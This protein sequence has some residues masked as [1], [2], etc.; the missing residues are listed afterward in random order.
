MKFVVLDF[1]TTGTGSDAEIIQVGL[2]T[3]DNN[4]ITDRYASFVKPEQPIPSFITQLTGIDDELVA[5]APDIE[6]VMNDMLPFLVDRI[7]VG[8]QVSFD[9]RFLQ[10]ELERSGY[11]AFDGAVLDTQS[12]LRICFPALSSLQL[13]NVCDALDIHHERP[14]RADSDAE[15]TAEIWLKCL[16]RIDALP[17]LTVQRLADIFSNRTGNKNDDLAWFLDELKQ[18][19]E[20]QTSLDLESSNYFRQFAINVDDWDNEKPASYEH[21]IVLDE[22]FAEF[23]D[24]LKDNLAKFFDDFEE[25]PAQ[26]EMI[27]EVHRAFEQ[28]QHLMIEAGTGT[29]KSLGYLIPALFYG[30]QQEEKVIVSTHTINLQEQ[31][32]QRD[33]PLLEKLFPIPF[34]AA[35]LKGRNHYLC[36]RKFEQKINGYD[37][38]GS[39]DDLYT[40]AQ[41]VVWLGETE[42][43][44]DE[45]IHFGQGGK[46]FWQTVA[47]DTDSCLNRACPWFKKCFYHRARHE[48]NIADVVITNHSMLF[49]DVKADNRLLPTYEHLVIDEAHHFEEVAT[50]HLGL[51]VQYFSFL[52]S[53]TYLFKDSSTGFLPTLRHHIRD[54]D[55]DKAVEWRA[56]IDD[57][58]PKIIEAKENWDKLC[59]LLYQYLTQQGGSLEVGAVLRMKPGEQPAEWDTLKVIEDN[60]YLE[61]TQVLKTVERMITAMKDDVDSFDVQSLVTDGNGIIKSIYIHLDALRFFMK[62]NDE[63]YVYWMEASPTYRSKSLQL[64]SVPIDVSPLLEQHFFNNKQSVILTSA[65]LTVDRSFQYS[66]EQL[67][68]VSS[69][70]SE[71]LRTVILPPT[72]NFREQ[73][74]VCIPRDFPKIKGAAGEFEFVE[75][76]VQSL[77]DVA[78]V[79]RGRMLVLFTSY[80]MLR[81]VHELLKDKMQTSGI[82]VLGQGIDSNNRSKLIHLFQNGSA[83]ILLGTSSFWEGIDIP[84]EALSCL[85][86][87]RLPFQPPNQPIVEAKSDHI[88]KQNGNP[89]MKLSVPQAVIRFKQGFGRLVRKA[90]DRGI[91][92]IYDTRVIE[93]RYGKNFLYSL[94]GPKIEHMLTEQMVPRIVQWFYIV[95]EEG[96]Q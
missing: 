75:S 21:D 28:D 61:L 19:K 56:T 42:H 43:G 55:D 69:M 23:Y 33:I 4:K 74:L 77:H 40:A 22:P 39:E 24:K 92:I 45:E 32:R 13:S 62:M 94:P 2:V 29:G 64:Y 58:Y 81:Q 63:D 57:L 87:V 34:R 52:N 25:R 46:Q 10:F 15:V 37:Y 7:L 30:L 89:F 85:A 47:S 84:G 38:E 79:T 60:I 26:D 8:H 71:R 17:L 70:E 9:L 12:L 86:I 16:D 80:R 11:S 3:I 5:D 41:M 1:E 53:L 50:K 35:V 76:L 93:T 6:T 54:V 96:K 51:E 44:D 78:I 14:H 67:G 73:A 59:D 48:A 27:Q 20:L 83:S 65:T 31:I 91:V 68:L 49:T 36:L 88:K 90:T 72:F 66:A 18:Q 95:D 82:E